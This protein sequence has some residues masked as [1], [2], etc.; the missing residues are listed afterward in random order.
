MIKKAKLKILSK[1]IISNI[2]Y[3][4]LY[5]SI[6]K[7]TL[8][9]INLLKKKFFNIQIDRVNFWYNYY[10]LSKI[11][12]NNYN[13]IVY[14]L[15]ILRNFEKNSNYKLFNSLMSEV[16]NLLLQEKFYEEAKILPLMFEKDNSDL[17]NLIQERSEALKKITFE[18]DLEIKIDNRS[19]NKP[20]ISIIVSLF[21]AENKIENF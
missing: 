5:I 19:Q 13:S 2:F 20:K 15:R 1:N 18:D 17:K 9:K 12:N 10:K 21:K 3:Y 14:G 7:L 8:R 6:Y 16:V 4:F 11:E